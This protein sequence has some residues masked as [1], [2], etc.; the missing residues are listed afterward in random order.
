MPYWLTD[1]CRFGGSPVVVSGSVVPLVGDGSLVVGAGSPVVVAVEPGL[2]LVTSPLPVELAVVSVVVVAEVVSVVDPGL[3]PQAASEHARVQV[4]H[5]R[6]C[7]R[8]V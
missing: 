2:V 6:R 1:I 3:P 5:S 8:R 4:T 7:M